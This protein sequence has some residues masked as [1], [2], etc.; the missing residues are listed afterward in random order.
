MRPLK[1]MPNFRKQVSR[2][3]KIRLSRPVLEL[4]KLAELHLSSSATSVPVECMFSTA[5]YYGKWSN[6]SAEKLHRICFVHDNHKLIFDCDINIDCTVLLITT[7][8]CVII[9]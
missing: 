3:K 6:L 9:T 8:M 5:E 7:V 4:Y 1:T 2:R